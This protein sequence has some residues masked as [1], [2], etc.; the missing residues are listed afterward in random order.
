MSTTTAANE[1]TA[2]AG[3]AITVT[4]SILGLQFD[5]LLGGFVGALVAQTLVTDPPIEGL[6]ALQRY[7]RVFAQLLAAGMLAGFLTPIA[8]NILAGLLPPKVPVHALHM[9]VAGAIGMVAPVV[10]PALRKLAQKLAE[11]P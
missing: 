11:R 4:G 1:A 8:E 6:T 10:V 7:V 5:A 3:V 9:A 2:A